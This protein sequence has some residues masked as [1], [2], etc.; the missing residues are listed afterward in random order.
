ML[1]KRKKS[2]NQNNQASLETMVIGSTSSGKT[3]RFFVSATALYDEL[4]NE[5]VFF[6]LAHRKLFHGFRHEF[7][8]Q[9]MMDYIKYVATP[10]NLEDSAVECITNG[11]YAIL[12]DIATNP[13]IAKEWRKKVSQMLYDS[14]YI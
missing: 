14:M 12:D 9:D 8:K 4:T 10:F 7:F 13:E 6:A 1:F 11:A 3:K 5:A 2:E